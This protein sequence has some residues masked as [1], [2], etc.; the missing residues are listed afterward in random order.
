MKVE[1]TM[2]R[3]ISLMTLYQPLPCVEGWKQKIV[4]E[5]VRNQMQYHVTNTKGNT[6]FTDLWFSMTAA[7]EKLKGC[8][9][10]QYISLLSD[11]KSGEELEKY[12][13]GQD[14]RYALIALVKTRTEISDEDVEK[15]LGK[16]PQNAKWF[17]TLDNADR[18]LFFSNENERDITY[19]YDALRNIQ[20]SDGR[21]IYYSLYALRGKCRVIKDRKEEKDGKEENDEKLEIADIKFMPEPVLLKKNVDS[22]ERNW[23]E[24]TRSWIL[25]QMRYSREKRDKRWLSYYQSMCQILNLLEQYEQKEKFK[26]L[27][28]IYFPAFRLFIEQLKQAQ[29]EQSLLDELVQKNAKQAYIQEKYEKSQKIEE[30]ASR[31]IDSMEILIHHLGISC[32]NILN[33]DGRNGLAY[34]VPIKLCMMY[35]AVMYE[36]KAILNDKEYEYQFFL[37]PLAY[38]RP[39]TSIYD[40]GL[41]PESRL[42]RIQVSR[43]QMYSPRA[44]FALLAHECGHYIGQGTRE[45]GEREKMYVQIVSQVIVEEMFP[46]AVF[47]ENAEKYKGRKKKIL[48]EDWIERKQRVYKLTVERIHR[49]VKAKNAKRKHKYHFMD[50]VGD[51]RSAVDNFVVADSTGEFANAIDTVSESLITY[52]NDEPDIEGIRQILG[53][54]MRL[55]KKNLLRFAIQTD[56]LEDLLEDIRTRFKEIV[57]DCGS[58]LLLELDPISYLEA[59]QLSEGNIPDT[60]II[61]NLL[62]YR[63]AVLHLVLREKDPEWKKTW[64]ELQETDFVQSDFLWLVKIRVDQYVE[65]YEYLASDNAQGDKVQAE[66]NGTSDALTLWSTCNLGKQYLEKVYDRLQA[67]IQRSEVKDKL[68][69]LRKLYSYFKVYDLNEEKHTYKGFFKDLGKVVDDYKNAVKNA[70]EQRVEQEKEVSLQ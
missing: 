15:E 37:T 7:S 54:Q 41:E 53:M 14:G 13:A 19:F 60:D 8:F 62:I 40:L 59:Y 70:W 23:C 12:W 52:L 32:V 66:G 1:E 17:Y 9:T 6:N 43:H 4:I 61:N 18:I 2:V 50:L 69:N 45:R 68:A 11:E 21:S 58:I 3:C 22:P 35:L 24:R 46:E 38:S 26:D 67:Y 5:M 51:V 33:Q 31:F 16:L 57:A 28:Y 47:Y 42:L 20:S 55:A 10:E 49:Q 48:E 27:F 64:D 29:D 56:G 30:A 39:K 63:I 36:I 65:R 34:D 25:S 44:L